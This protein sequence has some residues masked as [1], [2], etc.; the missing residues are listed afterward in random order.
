MLDDSMDE[1][2]QEPLVEEVQNDETEPME[3][4]FSAMHTRCQPKSEPVVV[5][6]Y[7]FL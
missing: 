6:Q 5:V 2:S 3:G 7:L 1:E 4:M